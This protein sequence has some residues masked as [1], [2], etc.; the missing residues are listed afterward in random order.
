[1]A[2]QS[3]IPPQTDI[4]IVGAGVSG[5]YAAWRLLRQNKNQ[6]ITI[7][8][9]L[10]RTGGRLDSDLVK[11]PDPYDNENVIVKEEE[12]GMRFE[13]SMASLMS[14]FNALHLCDDAVY[15]P[16]TTN[17]YAFRGHSFTVEESLA[18]DNTIWGELYDLEPAE[19][20]QSPGAI[21]NTIYTRILKANG[22][23]NPPAA[24]TP[25]FWQRF[26]LDF[27]WD[28]IPL[29]QWQLRGLLSAMGYSEECITM[30]TNTSGFRALFQALPNAGEAWQVLEDFPANPQYFTL[31]R[32]FSMLI[33]HLEAA[34]LK[35]GGEIFLGTNVESIKGQAGKYEVTLN[36]AKPGDAAHAFDPKD[37]LGS[38]HASKIILAIPSQPMTWLFAASPT[39]NK[40][41]QSRQ[42]WEDINAVQNMRLMKINLYFEAPWWY[43]GTTGQPP[44]A[45]GPS[46][47]DLPV[48]SVYPF[49]SVQTQPG[50]P[51]PG[52]PAA[53]TIYC[54]YTNTNYWEGLQNVGPMFDSPLQREHEKNPETLFPASQAVVQ[55]AIRQFKILFKT[56]Y[57][58]Q[59]I[60]TSYR[61]WSGA[62]DFPFAYHQW[63]LNS[64]DRAVIPRMA[65]PLADEDI[66]T[67]NE[68]WSDMQGWVNGSLRSTDYM[69]SNY[70]DLKPIT[71]E[72]P[73][74]PPFIVPKNYQ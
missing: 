71:E 29:Y 54:D 27:K 3:K 47:T 23:E 28:G 32:G 67:C 50:E 7:L 43:D 69:L 55:E 5:L 24:P 72:F 64:N 49:Y 74:C 4:L 16:M 39:L 51:D 59:P 73:S 2:S 45:A 26:R 8:E 53:L 13:Q 42:F 44:V 18:G 37:A 48:N 57:V 22:V 41:P 11:I 38:I 35:M 33:R 61:L 63:G 62:N 36:I 34:V 58:P 66:F 46:F 10:N 12:G 14:L 21:L 20:N 6:K 19:E 52:K 30:L 9:R 31:K 68:A 60:L 70:F 40:N 65:K 56:H 1:M 25:E 17:R 15:F